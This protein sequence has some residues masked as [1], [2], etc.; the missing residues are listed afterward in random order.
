MFLGGSLNN[1]IFKKEWKKAE[2]IKNEKTE[3]TKIKKIHKH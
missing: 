1:N 3:T 2:Y